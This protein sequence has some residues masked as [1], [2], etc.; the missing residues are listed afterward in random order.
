MADGHPQLISDRV[1]SFIRFRGAWKL[2]L[3][4]CDICNIVLDDDIQPLKDLFQ[5]SYTLL[6]PTRNFLSNRGPSSANFWLFSITSM[7]FNLIF[8]ALLIR[9]SNQAIWG[10]NFTWMPRKLFK[11]NSNRRW[12]G[13]LHSGQLGKFFHLSA[14]RIPFTPPSLF[15]ICDFANNSFLNDC[16]KQLQTNKG[17]SDRPWPEVDLR[18]P[19]LKR[20]LWRWRTGPFFEKKVSGRARSQVFEFLD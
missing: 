1:H 6:L 14:S 16:R 7:Y 9:S 3:C 11:M 12:A 15:Q 2:F 4:Y 13:P 5:M 20:K 10:W 19:Q 18:D 8:R 17:R